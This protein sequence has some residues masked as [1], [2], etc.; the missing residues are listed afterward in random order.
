MADQKPTDTECSPLTSGHA[1]W[2][3]ALPWIACALVLAFVFRGVLADLWTVWT[4]QQDYSHGLLVIPF[5]GYLA[6]RRR[7]ELRHLA[8]PSWAGLGVLAAAFLLRE[9]GLRCYYGSAERFSLVA[10]IWGLVIL[11]GGWAVVRRVA[12]PLLLLLLMIPPPGQVITTITLPMQHAAAWASAQVLALLGWNASLEGNT[13]FLCG[14]SLEVAEACNGLRMVFA[15]L[16]LGIAIAFLAPRPVWERAT[17][18]ASSVLFGVIVNVLRIVVTGAASQMSGGAITGQ[19]HDAAGWFM[20]PVALA[21][22]WCEQHFLQS[23]FIGQPTPPGA[24]WRGAAAREG[25][26]HG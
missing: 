13:I 25:V 18:I 8:R 11:L 12:G 3:L 1:P 14:Q 26:C 16:T 4:T 5:A 17:I 7:A 21:A 22:L 23:L 9:A 20:M 24:S 2:R 6:W 19:V 10:A 15:I